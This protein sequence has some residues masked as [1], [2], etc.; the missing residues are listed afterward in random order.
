MLSI[1]WVL[2]VGVL[3]S[4]WGPSFLQTPIQVLVAWI[5][6]RRVV[7]PDRVC[8]CGFRIVGFK[9]T[10]LI[11]LTFWFSAHQ[12]K[13]AHVVASQIDASQ[14]LLAHRWRSLPSVEGNVY[15]C[16]GRAK[17]TIRGRDE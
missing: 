17:E 1:A 2:F 10:V 8:M 14:T 5:A 6:I 7:P 15:S 4:I 3:G 12:M 9:Q 16:S 13:Q 11:V